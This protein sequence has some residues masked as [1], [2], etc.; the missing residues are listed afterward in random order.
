MI[1]LKRGYF[2]HFC[3]ILTGSVQFK[4]QQRKRYVDKCYVNKTAR[5]A[6]CIQ[7]S[8]CV[9][10]YQNIADYG[11]QIFT[12]F[13]LTMGFLQLIF[14]VLVRVQSKSIFPIA[15]ENWQTPV[16]THGRKKRQKCFTKKKSWITITNTAQEELTKTPLILCAS[17]PEEIM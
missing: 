9:L 5:L 8:S 3:L 4:I 16:I 7:K 6:L 10:L 13:K 11:L 14:P 1:I 17:T 15:P 12:I 2:S